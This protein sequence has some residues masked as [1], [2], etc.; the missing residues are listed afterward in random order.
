MPDL[1]PLPS[2]VGPGE[3]PDGHFPSGFGAGSGPEPGEGQ[4]ICMV[5][6]GLKR[7]WGVRRPYEGR[8][9]DPRQV[10]HLASTASDRSPDRSQPY[11]FGRACAVLGRSYQ[12]FC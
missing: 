11:T 6:L 7:S 4:Y 12:G 1:G 5:A 3:G 10:V 2:L 9:E 8:P